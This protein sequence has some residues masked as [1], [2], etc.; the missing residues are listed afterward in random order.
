MSSGFETNNPRVH[1]FG[2]PHGI[3][4]LAE[5]HDLAVCGTQKRYVILT[6]DTPGIPRLE[7]ARFA[8]L[9]GRLH[10]LT[11]VAS[12]PPP[13][14]RMLLWSTCGHT[15]GLVRIAPAK[16]Y[17]MQLHVTINAAHQW[18]AAGDVRG[19]TEPESARPL[20]VAC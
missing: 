7:A 10:T 8:T 20:N 16:Q 6:I 3:E 4:I 13:V 2:C 18:R 19:G 12:R 9:P 14:R 11:V 17:R 5:E 1:R 15:R